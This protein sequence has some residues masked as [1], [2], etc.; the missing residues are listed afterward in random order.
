MPDIES[1]LLPLDGALP[2]GPLLEYDADFLALEILAAPCGERGVGDTRRDAEEP[3]WRQVADQALRLAA[4]TRDLRVAMHLCTAWLKTDGLAGWLQGLALLRGLLER[5]WEHVHPRLED[6]DPTERVNVLAALCAEDGLLGYLRHVP[7]IRLERIGSATLRDLRIVAGSLKT[8]DDEA[9]LS[10][11]VDHVEHILAQAGDDALRALGD[12]AM[13]AT[14]HLDAIAATFIA[15]DPGRGPD[16]DALYRELREWSAALRARLPSD[17]AA[18][19]ATGPCD[20]APVTTTPHAEEGAIHGPNDVRRQLDTICRW[21][22]RFE[23]SSPVAPLLR[24]ARRL[25][26]LDFAT[27]LAALA[28]GGLPEFR[29]LTG[30]DD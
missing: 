23:P 15:A 4:R 19:T 13:A 17:A 16:L 22:E 14:S 10:A 1:L 7:V 5:H 27:L 6:D 24:R 11:H 3:D 29:Q 21:Y 2:C 8:E 18:T 26:G 12:T 9:T 28:P 30:E 25:V 20:D